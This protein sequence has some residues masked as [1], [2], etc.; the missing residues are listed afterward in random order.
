MAVTDQDRTDR[1]NRNPTDNPPDALQPP[2][3]LTKVYIG[4]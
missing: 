3:R 1:R 4:S 2:T